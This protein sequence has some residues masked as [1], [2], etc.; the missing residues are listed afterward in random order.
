MFLCVVFG[1]PYEVSLAELRSRLVDRLTWPRPYKTKNAIRSLNRKLKA[2]RSLGCPPWAPASPPAR[3]TA[4]AGEMDSR[5]NSAWTA[6]SSAEEGATDGVLCP[7][8]EVSCGVHRPVRGVHHRPLRRRCAAASGGG[9][10]WP[11]GRRAAAG[12]VGRREDAAV[13]W[14]IEE[15]SCKRKKREE[16]EMKGIFLRAEVWG[17]AGPR[18]CGGR[19]RPG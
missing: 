9:G 12:A 2:I 19:T 11:L 7:D 17:R 8:A 16:K 1:S 4:A 10:L 5:R 6:S 18:G 13:A 3:W 14:S 15:G